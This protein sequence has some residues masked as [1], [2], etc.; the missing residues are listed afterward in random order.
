MEISPTTPTSSIA[1]TG[2]Q[3]GSVI[4][5]DFETFL[6]MLTAQARYQDPLEPLDS[7]EYAAQLAQFSMVEQQVLSNDILTS[8]TT[9][10]GSGNLAQIANWIGME[11]LT[12]AP[13][14]FDGAPVQ[15]RPNPAAIADEVFLVAR[16]E[17]GNEVQRI[18]IP[19]SA[20]PVDW[21]GV[22]SDG[23]PFGEGLYIF[24]V[25]SYAN[26][27]IILTEPAQVYARI[28]EARLQEGE[29][30]LILEGGS[31]IRASDVGSLRE[32]S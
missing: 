18:S 29:P 6:K 16:D 1:Q 31:A 10:L 26:G 27:E 3:T 22:S 14:Y 11:A 5:S 24:D 25:E 30:V 17:A 13:V 15:I 21:A 23:E 8:L 28:T 9:Q 4:S 7:S 20:E 12:T 32:A 19:V 2:V